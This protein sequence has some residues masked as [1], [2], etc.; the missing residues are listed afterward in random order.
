[1]ELSPVTSARRR[2]GVRA[3]GR[4]ADAFET[5]AWRSPSAVRFDTC[6]A[7]DPVV[8]EPTLREKVAGLPAW[9]SVVAGGVVA[10]LMG[11]LVGGMLA[12]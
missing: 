5:V 10:A 11:A 9:V 4:A 2:Q 7:N 8:A 3:C 6:V 12:V 1:M